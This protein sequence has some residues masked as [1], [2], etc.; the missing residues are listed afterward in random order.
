MANTRRTLD[1]AIKMMDRDMGKEKKIESYELGGKAITI[2]N[3]GKGFNLY[4]DGKYE[5]SNESKDRLH[6]VARKI[7][8]ED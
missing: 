6:D 2:T 8:G 3:D 1:R 5:D 4:I 7:V